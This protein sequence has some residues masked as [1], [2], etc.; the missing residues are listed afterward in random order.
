MMV[1]VMA[2]IAAS[3]VSVKPDR[4]PRGDGAQAGIEY[5]TTRRTCNKGFDTCLCT[6]LCTGW[7][8][9]VGRGWRME[10]KSNA[11]CGQRGVVVEGELMTKRICGWLGE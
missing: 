3:A 2:M 6:G 10:T 7:V 9:P 5:S 4:I 8:C 1:L 11:Q